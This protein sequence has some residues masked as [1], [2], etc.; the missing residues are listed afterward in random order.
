MVIGE[1]KMNNAEFNEVVDNRIDKI[2][3]TL[4]RKGEEYSTDDNR[5]H[6]FDVSAI[7]QQTT[8]FKALNGMMEKHAVS[9]DDMI[10]RP[11]IATPQMVEEKIG[12]FINYLIL[13]E[14]LF[15]RAFKNINK[16]SF[17]KL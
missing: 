10:Q 8:P 14:G 4:K 1:K 16:S 15:V 6:N 17:D 11:F 9:V 13:L 12:D 5:F 2:L 7:R 3:E